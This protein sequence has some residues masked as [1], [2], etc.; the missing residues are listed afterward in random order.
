LHNSSEQFATR[1]PESEVST[2]G[3]ALVGS[4]GS[5]FMMKYTVMSDTVHLASRVEGANKEYVSHILVSEATIAGA[6]DA[7]EVREIDTLVAFGQSIRSRS[8]RSWAARTN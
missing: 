3:E 8:S 7:V 1:T 2:T 5:E 6:T 4:I